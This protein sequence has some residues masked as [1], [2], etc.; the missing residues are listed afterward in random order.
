MTV[1]SSISLSDRQHAFASRLVEDGRFGS[2]SAVIQQGLELLQDKLE[3][4]QTDTEALKAILAERREGPATPLAAFDVRLV[5]MLEQEQP[6][7][8]LED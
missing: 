6:T 4:E 7:D 1:K 2:V 5:A 8:A 3:A